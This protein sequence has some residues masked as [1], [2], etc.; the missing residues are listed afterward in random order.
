MASFAAPTSNEWNDILAQKGENTFVVLKIEKKTISVLHTGK[1]LT[2]LK[3]ILST[4]ES[5]QSVLGVGFVVYG[6]DTRGGVTSKRQKAFRV[7][8]MGIRVSPM[9]RG[10]QL[11]C[12]SHVSEYFSS[13]NIIL[14][15]NSV[16]D[17]DEFELTNQL[18]ASGGAHKPKCYDFG[19]GANTIEDIL[20]KKNEPVSVPTTNSTTEDISKKMEAT[21]VTNTEKKA[22]VATI[23]K[24]PTSTKAPVIAATTTA[25]TTTTTTTTATTTTTNN[26][27]ADF[28]SSQT[29][30]IL[31]TS[32]YGSGGGGQAG[33]CKKLEDTFAALKIRFK[34]IDGADA[35]NKEIR[36]ELFGISGVRGNYPQTFLKNS[37]GTTSFIGDYDA[38][39]DLIE[40]NDIPDDILKQNPGIQTFNV[41]FS[42]C[43]K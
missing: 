16:D 31:L 25:T 18:L 17:L 30:A 41:V 22:P 9:K 40:S 27:T 19:D 11:K 4:P 21:T 20:A 3:K 34:N 7:D 6:V 15:S 23:Q 39:I 2:K 33:K 29:H 38:L 32:S 35:K 42:E 28:D 43:K 36:N 37:D 14:Q 10:L 26:D 12:K 13:C 24:V 8:W 5:E 1:G